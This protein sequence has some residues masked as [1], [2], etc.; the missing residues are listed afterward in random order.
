MI[1]W[2]S[3]GVALL[4]AGCGNES[5][6][7]DPKKDAGFGSYTVFPADFVAEDT[8]MTMLAD[9]DGVQLFAAPQGGHVLHIAA[10][11]QGMAGQIANIRARIRDSDTDEI[12]T[13]EARDVVWKPVPG[14]PESKQP[15]IRS[16]SQ[17]TH[18]P[19]CPNYGA[20]DIVDRAWTLELVITGV[21]VPGS[22]ESTLSVVPKCLESGGDHAF[23]QCE[24]QAGYVLG[25]CTSDG[26]A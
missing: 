8:P 21:D 17:V 9:G 26:G 7:P 15:D 13:Q 12:V 11:V 1:R 23:C 5:A 14:E 24:C 22:G 10:K 6:G 20:L 3:L 2:V 19:A 4:V 25:K 16:I 18:V